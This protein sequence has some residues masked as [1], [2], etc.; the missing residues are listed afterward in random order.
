MLVPA[1]SFAMGDALSEGEPDERPVRTVAIRAFLIGKHEV[2]KALWDEVAVWACANGYDIVPDDAQAEGPGHPVAFVSWFEAAKWCNARS[3]REGRSPC[4]TVCG[5]A[6][7][8]G[9]APPECR[10]DADGYRLPTEAEWERAARGG[11]DGRRYPWSDSD[12]IDETRLNFSGHH[13][14]TMPVGTFA[15]NGYGLYDMAGNV[16]EWCWDWY[17]YRRAL[18]EGEDPRGPA[19]GALRVNRGGSWADV[20]ELCRVADRMA[21]EPGCEGYSLGF[22]LVRSLP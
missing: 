1:G 7:R 17:R 13:G 9:E 22:R 19:T 8:S 16:W 20:A 6:F 18:P 21:D 4:Y 3:E 12:A 2:T 5:R 10:W 14:S 15:P 11:A